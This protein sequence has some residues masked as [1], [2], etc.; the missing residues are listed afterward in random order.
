MFNLTHIPST[1]NG[2]GVARDALASFYYPTILRMVGRNEEGRNK[3]GR[4]QGR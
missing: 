4:E 1:Y 3:K 2:L